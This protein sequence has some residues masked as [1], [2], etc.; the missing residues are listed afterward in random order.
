[1][2]RFLAQLSQ[3][4]GL[5][6]QHKWID[7]VPL[8]ANF[9][10]GMGACTGIVKPFRHLLRATAHSQL[11]VLELQ[12]CKCTW[13]LTWDNTFDKSC[14]Q[15]PPSHKE[16]WFDEQSQNLILAHAFATL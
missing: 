4:L 13:A 2:V 16:K 9:A 12:S 7:S 10:S 15:T 3:P 11:L 1:M 6:G 5:C 8:E 14:P